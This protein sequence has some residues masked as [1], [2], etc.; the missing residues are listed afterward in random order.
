M[1]MIVIH[2]H[3]A[4]YATNT[5]DIKKNKTVQPFGASVMQP[6]T[7]PSPL[8]AEDRK[9][10]RKKGDFMK[11]WLLIC[12]IDAVDVD[13]ETVLFSE[14]EPVFWTCND[15]AQ[16]NGYEFWTICEL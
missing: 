9:N 11:K 8:N 16:A 4:K 10:K 13:F 6:Q 14:E 15:I 3:I 12:S 1:K 2:A 7:V 5:Q